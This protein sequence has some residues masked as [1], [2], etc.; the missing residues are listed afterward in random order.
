MSLER[1]NILIG[2]R[3]HSSTNCCLHT[4]ISGIK[5]T[6]TK[7]GHVLGA[8]MYSIEIDGVR[9]L[10]TGDYSMEEDRHLPQADIP[11]GP[12]PD[13]LIVESTFGTTT[14]SSREEREDKFIRTVEAIITRRG[15]TS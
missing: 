1:V 7:A 13:V 14:L 2:S 3:C 4:H 9:I 10:Y 12:P 15:F 5:F 6:A 8:C 11:M